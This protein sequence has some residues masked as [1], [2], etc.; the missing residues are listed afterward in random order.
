MEL[1]TSE[2]GEIENFLTAKGLVH[3]D[4]R[5]EI[6]DHM[7]ENITR[8]MNTEG[9]DFENAFQNEIANWKYDLS[10]HSSFWLG[11]LWVSPRIVINKCVRKMRNIYLRLLL[12]IVVFGIV[13]FILRDFMTLN[14]LS[15][16]ETIIGSIYILSFGFLLFFHFRIKS[17]GYVTS[18]SFLFKINAVG[19]GF[20]YLLNNPL[21]IDFMEIVPD[22]SL[23]EITLWSHI[24]FLSFSYYFYAFYR[25]HM[26]SKKLT[27]E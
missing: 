9:I 5:L 6:L 1:T 26:A 27:I 16:I 17:T 13:F 8:A 23:S 12:L 3:I 14:V 20:V 7:C 4:I 24:L 10:E 2:I 19:L 18:Y 11:M 25:E 15:L 22:G 21:W